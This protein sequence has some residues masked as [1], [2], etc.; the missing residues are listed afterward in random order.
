MI[1]LFSPLSAAQV[2]PPAASIF[3]LAPTYAAGTKPCSIAVAD[4]NGDLRL[5]LAVAD[6]GSNSVS[7]LLGNGDGTFQAPVSYAAGSAPS[8][9]AIGDFNNDGKLD[10]AV[11]N[12]GSNNVSVLLGNGD[13]TFQAAVSYNAGTQPSAGAVGDLNNDNNLDLVVANQSDNDVSVLLGNGDGTF[14]AA[15]NYAVASGPTSVALGYFTASHILDLA[16][17]NRGTNNISVLL[18]NGDGTFGG[19]VNYGAGQGSDPVSIIVAD[20]NG[21]GKPDLAVADNI[22]IWIN[23]LLGNGDGTFQ[24]AVGHEAG[25]FPTGLAAGDFDGDGDLDLVVSNNGSETMTMLRGNG[26][27]TFQA[28]VNYDAAADVVAVATGDF[29][30]DG[31]LDAVVVNELTNNVGVFLGRG[32]LTFVGPV[33]YGIAGS[34][35]SVAAGV[36]GNTGVMDLVASNGISGPLCTPG[37][38]SVLVGYGNGGF[39]V[40]AADYATDVGARGMAVADFN[41]DGWTDVAVANRGSNN[42]SVLLGTATGPF[43]AASD[44]PAGTSPVALAAGDFNGDQKLDLAVANAGA[45]GV[46]SNVSVLIGNG[47]GSFQPPVNYPAGIGPTSVAVGDFNGDGKLDLVVA[48]AG[49]STEFGTLSVFIGNGDGTFQAATSYTLGIDPTSVVIADFNGDGELDLAVSVSGTI[50]ANGTVAVLLGN[51]DG[52]FG[53]PVT[54]GVGVNPGCLAEGDFNGDGKPDLVTANYGAAQANSGFSILLGNG[55]GTFQTAA[56]YGVGNGTDGVT[57]ADFNKDG[58]PDIALTAFVAGVTVLLN[59]GGTNIVTTGSPNPSNVGQT[60]TFTTTI[61]ASVS[62]ITATPTGTVTY[63]D[64]GTT[65]GSA[66]LVSGVAS[67]ST[68]SLS[69]GTQSITAIYSGDSNFNPHT[70]SP[71]T[72]TVNGQGPAVQLSPTSLTF[73]NQNVGTTSPPQNITMTNT[74]GSTLNITSI[75]ASG[76][77]AETNTCGPTLAAGAN[78]MISV[79]FAPTVEG[80]N[81]GALTITDDASGSPQTAPLTGTGLAPLVTLSPLSLTFAAQQVGTSSS[82]Q[83]VTLTNSGNATLTITSIAVTGTNKGDF[84]QTHTCQS[85]LAAGANCTINVIFKPTAVGTRSATLS[86]T[87]NATGSPQTVSLTGTGTGP[88]ASLSPSKL[89]FTVQLVNTT[90]PAQHVTLTNTGTGTLTI[91]SITF[92]GT[93]G[94]DYAETNTCGSS[95]GAGANCTINVTFTPLAAGTRI[96]YL[97]VADN[98]PG[99]PQKVSLLGTGTVMSVTPDS[100]NFGSIGVGTTSPPETVTIMNTGTSSVSITSVTKSGLNAKDFNITSSTCGSTLGTGASCAVALTFTPGAVG[101]RTANLNIKDTGGGSPQVVP[102]S[103]TGM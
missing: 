15:V 44:Y 90:S 22:Q 53:S 94:A 13:G 2:G 75:V 1:A 61:S 17:A 72:Q 89:T 34:P 40:G 62:G 18:G 91:T 103:G 95:V 31:H 49:I 11:A 28:V 99:S 92:T 82:P 8:S 48:N 80:T 76:A 65:L 32:D 86:V 35:E 3:W 59:N 50:G 4:L 68:A 70:G 100:L 47:D 60:V 33:S 43:E 67:F 12:A 7:I 71:Y 79:T 52:T 96:A 41:S 64:N 16:V 55:D 73:A 5:D 78:C 45:R 29:N 69:A 77:F 23:V 21:D 14:K 83:P 30:N 6:S 88:G 74:G 85:S 46:A 19:A 24:S 81:A 54:Y 51:G 39:K 87:D 98:A 20:L 97:S 58:A 27:G 66:S 25:T 36:F 42:V 63:L 102:L 101:S 10:L 38:V 57:V 37:C 26:D 9:V 93:D 84:I 56:T